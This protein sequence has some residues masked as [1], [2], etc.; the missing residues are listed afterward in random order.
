MDEVGVFLVKSIEW[1]YEQEWRIMR[2]IPDANE[3]LPG[4]RYPICLFDFPPAALTEVI[5][6][7]R[8]GQD[9]RTGV[10]KTLRSAK[11]F[12]HVKVFQAVVD[13]EDF[14]IRI[15]KVKLPE[16]LGAAAHVAGAD[17]EGFDSPYPP[18]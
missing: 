9:N 6:G 11:H 12:G 14:K 8:M 16:N 17:E 3:S 5:L 7:A 15:E 18:A 10:I 13:E 4:E 1:E 2:A